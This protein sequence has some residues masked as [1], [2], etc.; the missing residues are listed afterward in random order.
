MSNKVIEKAYNDRKQLS[1][2]YNTDESKIIW[3][4]NNKY[5]V[6]LKNGVEIR[7]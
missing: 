1:I 2:L 6:I 4:G 3:C 5:I 7:L